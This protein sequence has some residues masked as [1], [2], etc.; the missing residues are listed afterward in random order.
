MQ[1]FWC[2]FPE[3]ILDEIATNESSVCSVLC[4][5]IMITNEV[6]SVLLIGNLPSSDIN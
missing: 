1:V 4:V 6:L 5:Q 3:S 2:Y